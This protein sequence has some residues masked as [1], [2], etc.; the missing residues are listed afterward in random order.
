L[1][2]VGLDFVWRYLDNAENYPGWNLAADGPGY[3]SLMDLLRRLATEAE[4][5]RSRT[6]EITHPTSEALAIPNNPRSPIRVPRRL[7]IVS[8]STP[9]DWILNELAATLILTIGNARLDSMIDW[10]GSV[11]RAFDTSFGDPP[12]LWFWGVGPPPTTVPVGSQGIGSA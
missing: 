3:A 10:L 12:R 11:D 7:R 6:T 9:G 5:P 1:A 4:S 2:T 8:S